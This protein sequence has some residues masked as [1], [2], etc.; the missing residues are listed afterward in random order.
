MSIPFYRNSH[1]SM[2]SFELLVVTCQTDTRKAYL[3]FWPSRH[4]LAPELA[5]CKVRVCSR[6]HQ[7]CTSQE[8]WNQKARLSAEG[9][10]IL[11][12]FEPSITLLLPA[13]TGSSSGSAASRNGSH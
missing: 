9:T 12:A 7:K 11:V 4:V 2:L 10:A 5:Y 1:R 3:R 13:G 8:T 6:F